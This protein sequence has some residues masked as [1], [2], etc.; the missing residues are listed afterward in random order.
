MDFPAHAKSKVRCC[1][2]T[3]LYCA[4]PEEPWRPLVCSGAPSRIWSLCCISAC[5]EGGLLWRMSPHPRCCCCPSMQKCKLDCVSM[6]LHATQSRGRGG[7]APFPAPGG[8]LKR[9]ASDKRLLAARQAARRQRG[10]AGGRERRWCEGVGQVESACM[11]PTGR[12]EEGQGSGSKSMGGR[13]GEEGRSL[14][15]HSVPGGPAPAPVAQ[16]RLVFFM[17]R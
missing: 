14:R 15:M 3:T 10:S 5:E 13:L 7:A 2:H 4:C 17:M 11:Q 9:S 1:R 8:S 12:G 16:K 6:W